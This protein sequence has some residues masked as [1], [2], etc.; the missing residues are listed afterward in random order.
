MAK[1]AMEDDQ[2]AESGSYNSVAVL[3]PCYNEEQTVGKVVADYLRY[4]PGSRI[5]VFDNNSSDGTVRRAR[6]A[7]ATVVA[8]H[9][10]G[11]GHVVRHMFSE[12]EAE[13]YVMVDGDDTYPA[14]EAPRLVDEFLRVRADM[15]VGTRI[16]HPEVGAFRAFHRF[17][18][19]LVA[20]LISMLFGHLRG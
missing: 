20:R 6:E 12:V 3:I 17:G 11:K 4:L 16:E 1:H 19:H 2:V 9:R 7:G 15:V 14:E 8:S 13:I 10:Q 5:L 18:N